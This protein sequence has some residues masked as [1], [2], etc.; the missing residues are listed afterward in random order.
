MVV[1]NSVVVV[2]KW[3]ASE[4]QSS[5][6][7]L[8]G[9]CL[10]TLSFN[11]LLYGGTGWNLPWRLIDTYLNWIWAVQTQ[12]FPWSYK[13]K[14]EMVIQ[15]NTVISPQERL[16]GQLILPID[17]RELDLNGQVSLSPSSNLSRQRRGI[18]TTQKLLTLVAARTCLCKWLSLPS[19]SC[20]LAQVW[21]ICHWDSTAQ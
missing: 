17:E 16:L 4:D 18:F 11:I 15:G 2:G 9:K 7:R 21:R 12:R 20:G 3:K 8:R 14:C 1:S 19:S 13:D 10:I 6:V 5:L